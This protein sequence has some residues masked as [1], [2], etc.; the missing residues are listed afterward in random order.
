MTTKRIHMLMRRFDAGCKRVETITEQ[1]AWWGSE[2]R[3]RGIRFDVYASTS[4]RAEATALI[5]WEMIDA[6]DDGAEAKDAVDA[7]IAK[8]L[9]QAGYE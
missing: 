3:Y 9:K 8:I 5:T 6:D 2:L 1:R 4:P 7:C